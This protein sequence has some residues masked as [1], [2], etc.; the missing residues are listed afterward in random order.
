RRD[1]QAQHPQQDPDQPGRQCERLELDEVGGRR[2]PEGA[3]LVAGCG[4]SEHDKGDHPE[5]RERDR[6]LPAAGGRPG[7]LGA[8]CDLDAHAYHPFEAV[9]IGPSAR[10]LIRK[11]ARTSG[12][13]AMNST[14]SDWTT[15][16]MSIGVPVRACIVTPPARRAPNSSPAATVP[17]GFAR[18]RSATVI[19][20]KPIPPEMCTLP[21]RSVPS[22]WAA[23]ARP[24]SAPAMT[25]TAMYAPDTDMPA[26]FAAF[27]FSPTARSWKPSV[28]R[29]S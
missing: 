15:S 28:L 27:G 16:T 22:A 20:S 2:D 3:G 17:H 5:D 8:V 18:P 13:A 25:N 23:P 29:F 12:G 26:V 14:I 24:A 21:C 19:A 9:V 7:G 1:R 6:R 11:I 10:T 4:E